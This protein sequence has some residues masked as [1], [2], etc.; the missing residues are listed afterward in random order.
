MGSHT[1]PQSDQYFVRIVGL[2]VSVSHDLA[3]APDACAHAGN[4]CLREHYMCGSHTISWLFIRI[5][6]IQSNRILLFSFRAKSFFFQSVS[7]SIN[8]SATTAITT[9]ITTIQRSLNQ[10]Q[11]A[12]TVII[13]TAA[14]FRRS[15]S[16]LSIY[17]SLEI[18]AF[19][20]LWL[21]RF[22]TYY[23]LLAYFSL[24][25]DVF[26]GLLSTRSLAGESPHC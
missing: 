4:T 13:T 15:L 20:G 14:I 1:L 11:S 12:T 16:L 5:L 23:L 6:L 3:A 10:Y 8:Q 22:Q 21:T 26:L 7:Q 17:L 18:D 9:A 25:I 2:W 19:L 24:E